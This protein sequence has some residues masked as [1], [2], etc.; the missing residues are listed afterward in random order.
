MAILSGDSMYS[1]WFG[2]TMAH[3]LSLDEAIEEIER[4]EELGDD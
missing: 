1:V 4:D 3:K 2:E